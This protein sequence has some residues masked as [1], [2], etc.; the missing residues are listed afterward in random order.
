MLLESCPEDTVFHSVAYELLTAA[1][2]SMVF[3]HYVKSVSIHLE[4]GSSY[5]PH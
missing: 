4:I 5:E 3:G 2:L 1:L